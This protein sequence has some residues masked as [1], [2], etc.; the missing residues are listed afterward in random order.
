MRPAR[1]AA[2]AAVAVLPLVGTACDNP[3]ETLGPENEVTV[4]NLVGHFQLTVQDMQ[5]VTTLMTFR[6]EN[7][8]IYAVIDH[9]SFT[10][11]GTTL[12]IVTDADGKEVYRGE[13]LYQLEDRTLDGTPGTWVVQ[14][15]LDQSVGNIDVTLDAAWPPD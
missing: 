10:P 13:T 14:F 1:W 5:N 3:P 15:S 2:V 7:P 6:W 12:V 4:T 9:Q 8:G 11:H